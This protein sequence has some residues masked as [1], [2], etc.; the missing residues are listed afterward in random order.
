MSKVEHIAEG[1][2]LYL[3]DCRD[4]LPALPAI[5]IL[6]TSPPY[7]QQRDYGQKIEDW[8][9]LVGTI[10]LTPHTEKT[11]I[12]V[13]LGLIHRNNEIFEYWEPL[14]VSMRSDGWRFFGWY[15]WDKGFGAPGNWNGRLA[16]AHEFVFHFNK[17]SR[18]PNKWVPTDPQY[19]NR[20]KP[21]TGLRRADGSMSGI[22][23][24]EK[25]GQP[26]KVADSVIRLAPHQARGG[27]E[28]GHPAVYPVSLPKHL[29]ASFSNISEVVAD[30]F[31]GS[32]TTGVA[33]VLLGR[34][35]AGIELDQKYFDISCR[36]IA[37]ASRQ[38]DMLREI[39]ARAE[40]IQASLEIPIPPEAQAAE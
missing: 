32:G 34:K 13:N 33:A 19:A 15:I 40:E 30:P 9:D 20:S 38:P 29:I 21:G 6:V 3:G 4:I 1:V 10:G 11:Q 8:A 2:T 35:F 14:K 39:E 24:P 12:L 31:M 22:S 37:E 5:D 27:P 23:S 26:F 36:R 28:S 7:A 16:P 18:Q 25:C 17:V